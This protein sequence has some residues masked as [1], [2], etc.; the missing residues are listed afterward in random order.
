MFQVPVSA[1]PWKLAASR[2]DVDAKWFYRFGPRVDAIVVKNSTLYVIEAETRRPVNG[3]SELEVYVDNLFSNPELRPYEKLELR[4]QLV[5]T[6]FD[7]HV[8][9]ICRRR[10][11]DYVLFRP[12]WINE[13]LRR[14]GIIE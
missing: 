1:K 12:D 4:V 6:I 10:R 14:W 3:L 13:H 9:A 8:A 7:E 5:T 2:K 11:W